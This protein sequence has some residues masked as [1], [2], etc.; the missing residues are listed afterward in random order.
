[1]LSSFSQSTVRFAQPTR[2]CGCP[3]QLL[4]PLEL[5]VVTLASGLESLMITGGL[6]LIASS[7]VVPGANTIELE[8]QMLALSSHLFYERSDL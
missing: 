4:S 5:F 8:S 1:M 3:L 6:D 2:T 7:L